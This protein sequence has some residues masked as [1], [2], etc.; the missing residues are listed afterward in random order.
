VCHLLASAAW[1]GGLFALRRALTAPNADISVPVVQR[2]SRMGYI[3]ASIVVLTGVGNMWFV[4]KAIVPNTATSYG[5][6]LAIKIAFVAALLAVALFDR[7]V[8]Q[9]TGAT[10]LIRTIL[11]EQ[12]LFAA[13][14]IAVSIF[15]VM[16]PM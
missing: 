8:A 3:A 2:F 7:V 1:L 5:A 13:I 15:G 9:R 16:S 14:V 6:L 11:V 12:G 10:L 4:T